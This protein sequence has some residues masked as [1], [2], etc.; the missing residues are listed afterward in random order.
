[1]GKNSARSK[2]Y[3]KYKKEVKGYTEQEKKTIVIGFAVILVIVLC[4]VIIPNAIE[5]KD[6]LRVRKGV[7]QNVGDNWLVSDMSETS[8]HKYRKIAEVDPAEGWQVRE[9]ADGISDANEAYFYFEPVDAETSVADEYYAIV[10]K[11]KYD[12]LCTKAA[13]SMAGF[14]NE[15]LHKTET[16]TD[17]VDGRNI[18][19]YVLEYNMNVS[20]EED[21]PIYEYNQTVS[22]YIESPI[23]G[24]CVLLNASNT[25]ADESAFG[26]RDAIIEMLKEATKSVVLED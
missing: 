20:E 26:D 17:V 13:E 7:V 25:G 14:A 1:M 10:G 11:G 6:L 2:G 5:A 21:N 3:R 8:K 24:R 23:E 16:V 15:V 22:M 9:R 19:Y 12:E 4:A 18:A